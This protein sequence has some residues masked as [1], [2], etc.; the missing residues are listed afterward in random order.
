MRIELHD[1]KMAEMLAKTLKAPSK[2]D[3]EA[4]RVVN[5]AH[6]AGEGAGETAFSVTD[7]YRLHRV[8]FPGVMVAGEPVNVAAD[9]FLKALV[10]VGKAARAVRGSTVP[11]VL[12][13]V[14]ESVFVSA[15]DMME[16]AVPVR[17]STFPECR[18]IITNDDEMESGGCFEGSYMADLFAAAQHVAEYST[19]RTVPNAVT[20]ESLTTRKPARITSAS[21]DGRVRFVGILMPKR[22]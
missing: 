7:S 16:V 8:A 5:I 1:G 22:R 6:L 9:A 18:S 15:R 10:T 12:E 4:L 21:G 11:V 2:A 20:V 14:G 19:Y 3:R 17:F 13:M